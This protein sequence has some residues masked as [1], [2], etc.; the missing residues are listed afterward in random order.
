MRQRIR[1]VGHPEED[2]DVLAELFAEDIQE[3]PAD[4][5]LAIDDYHYA[6]ES[7]ASERFLDLVTNETPIQM[8]LTTRNRPSWAT[9]RRVLYG[10][11][12]ELDRRS[13]AMEDHEALELLGGTSGQ[14]RMRLFI[15][16][17]VG[18]RSWAWQQRPGI[19]RSHRTISLISCTTTSLR[20]SI[21]MRVSRFVRR[22]TD[23]LWSPPRASA[24]RLLFGERLTDVLDGCVRMGA[25]TRTKEDIVLHPLLRAFLNTKLAR[26]RPSDLRAVASETTALL[27]SLGDWDAAFQVIAEHSLPELLVP[28]VKAAVEIYWRKGGR[29]PSSTGST[30][31][32]GSISQTSRWMLPRPRLLSGKVVSQG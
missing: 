12:H 4:A 32:I 31:L 6:M 27:I 8:V 28:L 9:A 20:S 19:F 7:T 2:V 1:T 16:R 23:Y 30:S 15:E 10:E 21:A 17:G 29:K 13:L 22:F 18:L 11:I 14:R 5:W 26:E 25:V 24:A 3:W